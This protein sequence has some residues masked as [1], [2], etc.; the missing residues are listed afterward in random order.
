MHV[1][2]FNGNNGTLVIKKFKKRL[3]EL[4]FTD[5]D[6]LLRDVCIDSVATELYPD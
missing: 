5:T 2:H 4:D 1:S 3:M 6:T